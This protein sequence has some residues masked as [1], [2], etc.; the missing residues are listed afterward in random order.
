M[1][2]RHTAPQFATSPPPPRPP[3]GGHALT[4]TLG[5]KGPEA[6]SE[7]NKSCVPE[8]PPVRG[9]LERCATDGPDTMR[10]VVGGGGPWVEVDPAAV[11]EDLK[12]DTK[13]VEGHQHAA[14]FRGGVAEH[15]AIWSEG[16]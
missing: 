5:P 2:P 1:R 9:P 4:W 7:R 15:L 10:N 8:G 12:D 16:E 14:R 13:D 3:F 11:G 6:R